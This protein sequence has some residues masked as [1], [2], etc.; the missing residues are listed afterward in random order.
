MLF[1]GELSERWEAVKI[2]DGMQLAHL[3]GKLLIPNG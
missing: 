1:W 2:Q 3:L